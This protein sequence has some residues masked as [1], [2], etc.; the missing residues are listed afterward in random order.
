MRY[1]L[2]QNSCVSASS[3]R[4]D[5]NNSKCLGQGSRHTVRSGAMK[6][7]RWDTPPERIMPND[8]I[9]Y[10]EQEDRAAERAALGDGDYELN[11]TPQSFSS[12]VGST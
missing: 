10:F 7:R 5:L 6:P 1:V 2:L 12:D 11:L 9:K 8:E 4:K 3:R